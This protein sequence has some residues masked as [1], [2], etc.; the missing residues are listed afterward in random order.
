[1]LHRKNIR[2]APNI[3]MLGNGCFV[4]AGINA[5]SLLQA[6]DSVVELKLNGGYG[7]PVA[8]CVEENASTK[9]ALG[10]NALSDSI[11]R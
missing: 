3:P 8:D 6:V 2:T 7:I 5:H 11:R 1:M 9:Y 4:M 10:A